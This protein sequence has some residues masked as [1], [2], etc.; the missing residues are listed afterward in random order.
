MVFRK[1]ILYPKIQGVTN[2]QA[3]QSRLSVAGSKQNLG[4]DTQGCKAT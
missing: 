4:E 2:T 1:E 3:V